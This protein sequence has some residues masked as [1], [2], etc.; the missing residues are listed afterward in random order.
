MDFEIWKVKH[1]TGSTHPRFNFSIRGLD[2]VQVIHETKFMALFPKIDVEK[3][4]TAPKTATIEIKAKL[5]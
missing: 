1:G 3:V 5:K 4:P 2:G